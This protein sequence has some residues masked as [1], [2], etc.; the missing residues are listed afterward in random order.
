M[1]SII[2]R[3]QAKSLIQ[4]F[5]NQNK[6]SAEH[7]W[8]TPDGQHLHGF[9]IDRESLENLLS[10]KENAGIHVYLAK[11]PDFAGKADKVH[12]IALV[13]AQPNTA[14]GASTPYVND[15]DVLDMTPPCPPFCGSI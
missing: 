1:A 3:E 13:G 2:D 10:N 15:G 12:T 7:A 4:E 5:R 6:A 11:H 9:F 14:E 8:K